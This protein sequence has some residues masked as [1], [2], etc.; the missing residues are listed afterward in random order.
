MNRSDDDPPSYLELAACAATVLCWAAA[1]WL[2]LRQYRRADSRI[3][4]D[5]RAGLEPPPEGEAGHHE[6][7]EAER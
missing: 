2:L 6:E 5:V 4:A 1:A 3:A 7:R